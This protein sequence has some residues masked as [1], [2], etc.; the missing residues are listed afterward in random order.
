M[1]AKKKFTAF[2][3]D[4]DENVIAYRIF[5]VTILFLPI[6]VGETEQLTQCTGAGLVRNKEICHIYSGMHNHRHKKLRDS[7]FLESSF[8]S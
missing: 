8:V 5:H 4:V 2:S 3:V 7:R 1:N 6:C